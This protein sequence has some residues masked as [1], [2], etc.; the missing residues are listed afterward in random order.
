MKKILD[1][2]SNIKHKA[3]FKCTC[4]K[5]RI[6]KKVSVHSLRHLFAT[7]LLESGIDLRD[8]Q[9]TLEHKSSK[10]KEIHTHLCK[11]SIASI[12]NP[13]D[14]IWRKGHKYIHRYAFTYIMLNLK[15]IRNADKGVM[16]NWSFYKRR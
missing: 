6:K 2:T 14:V 5:V 11:P 16:C 7:H 1:T 8:I 15:Y 12:K 3:I 13:L 9:K 10:T 4:G